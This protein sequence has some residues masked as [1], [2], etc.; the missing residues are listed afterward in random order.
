M[1]CTSAQPGQ[2]N[3]EA[4]PLRTTPQAF[5]PDP[6][7][8]RLRYFSAL[9]N[10]KYPGDNLIEGP[11]QNLWY[12]N[13]ASGTNAY[14]LSKLTLSGT[15]TYAVPP[16]CS[17][18]G[19]IEP[20]S[21]VSG[22]DGRIWFGTALSYVIGAMDTSGNVKYYNGPSP[23]CDPTHCDIV[24]G[25]VVGQNIWFTAESRS[26]SFSYQLLA[27]YVDTVTSATKAYP[28]GIERIPPSP[29]VMGSNGNLWFGAGTQ[30][31][32][33]DTSGFVNFFYT[34]PRMKVGSI[35][36]GPDRDLWFVSD[37]KSQI[38]GRMKTDGK[39]LNETSLK[40]DEIAYQLIIGPDDR[41]W[42][43]TATAIVQM[44]SPTT[45]TSITVPKRQRHCKPAG[46]AVGSDGNLWFSSTSV[47][48]GCRRGLGTVLLGTAKE[49]GYGDR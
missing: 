30:V 36:S 16:L 45:Y 19:P 38:V 27:G 49:H 23:F 29:I 21:L 24:L 6:K 26:A 8:P 22:P 13:P 17:S 43:T 31:A 1:G 15:T 42:I 25:A 4:I 33:I 48:D 41:V 46:I 10:G 40:R 14:T 20:T 9:P 3:A 44:T 7:S 37:G 28:T 35:I 47:R 39:L 18:C 2:T 5:K 34:Y 12:T 11:D 32:M